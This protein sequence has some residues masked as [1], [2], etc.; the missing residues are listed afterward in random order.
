V[1]CYAVRDERMTA[2]IEMKARTTAF[3]DYPTIILAMRKW[4]D[5]TRIGAAFGVPALF[6]V[7][8]TDGLYMIDIAKVDPSKHK[9]GGNSRNQS[10]NDY[11]PMIHIPTSQ[12][13][14]VGR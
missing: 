2:V 13:K 7:R 5:L 11:E 9:M 4:L 1:D 3:G 14:R 12:F 8:F 6:V 10:F